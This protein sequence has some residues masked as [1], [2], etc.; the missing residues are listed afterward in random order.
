MIISPRAKSE[1]NYLQNSSQLCLLRKCTFRVFSSHDH[2]HMTC[3]LSRNL[4]QDL[5]VLVR[6]VSHDIKLAKVHL[7]RERNCDEF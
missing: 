2:Q 4:S 3:L 6:F 5:N 7:R 1:M